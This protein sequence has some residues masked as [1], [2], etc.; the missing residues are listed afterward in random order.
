M[1]D[2]LGNPAPFLSSRAP[3]AN[4]PSSARDRTRKVRE[5]REARPAARSAHGS[6]R[7]RA[8]PRFFGGH[9][10][11]D[12]NRLKR[13]RPDPGGNSPRSGGRNPRGP[14]RWREPAGW[15]R[16]LGQVDP[17]LDSNRSCQRKSARAAVY[18]RG[19]RPRFPLRTGGRG[20]ARILQ[21][22]G[23]HCAGRT[24]DRWP[25]RTCPDTPGRCRRATSASS[26]Y[27][28]ASRW[29]DRAMAFSPPAGSMPA[30]CPTPRPAGRG[31]PGVRPAPSA[32]PS[33]ERLQGHDDA[34]MQRPP[35]LQQE[36]AVGDLMRQGVLEGVLALG[37]EPRLVQ[38]L[39]RLEGCQT[40][41]QCRLG[42]L[43]N[44]LQQRQRTSV[45]MTAAV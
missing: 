40:P 32:G 36:T 39:G 5:S 23:A 3:S 30:P 38:E 35:P 33:G 11:P 12:D 16:W 13:R 37:I 26:K 24:G 22:D 1:I 29:A 19:S 6:D 42:E 44:G 15:T 25:A 14:W 18:R 20:C 9:L 8:P 27:P 4:S 10:P 31:G 28:T 17:S 43:G 45:P 41:M 21:V 7:L 2:C 34:G